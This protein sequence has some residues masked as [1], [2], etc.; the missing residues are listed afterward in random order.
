MGAA[1]GKKK[2]YSLQS[3]FPNGSGKHVVN[4]S[5]ECLERATPGWEWHILLSQ[6]MG[7][8]QQQTGQCPSFCTISVPGA[9]PC[10]QTR[11]GW[12]ARAGSSE[13]GFQPATIL[14]RTQGGGVLLKHSI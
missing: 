12:G 5:G 13:H 10:S 7:C 3:T 14:V 8:F 2:E 4:G 6:A 1:H 11:P 9:T